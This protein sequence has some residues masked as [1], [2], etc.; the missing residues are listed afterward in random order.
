MLKFKLTICTV[1]SGLLFQ[2]SILNAQSTQTVTKSYNIAD[3]NDSMSVS[4]PSFNTALGTLTGVNILF[5]TSNAGQNNYL[6]IENHSVT[7]STIE[8]SNNHKRLYIDLNVEG[9]TTSVVM[10]LLKRSNLPHTFTAYD[11][12]DDFAGTSGAIFADSAINYNYQQASTNISSFAG[13]GITEVHALTISGF[14]G[15]YEITIGGGNISMSQHTAYNVSVQVTYTYTPS[16]ALALN[17]ISFEGAATKEGNLLT[18]RLAD[19]KDLKTIEI[20]RS[21]SDEKFET[22][23]IPDAQTEGRFMDKNLKAANNLYRLKITD[24]SGNIIYS[25]IRKVTN[26]VRSNQ[27]DIIVYP[28]PATDNK[29]YIQSAMDIKAVTL[30]GVNGAVYNLAT[31]RSESNTFSVSLPEELSAGIYYITIASNSGTASKQLVVK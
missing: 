20:E 29:V 15:A 8:A 30:S 11:G 28:N 18:W 9:T 23:A 21:T 14:E 4:V 27:A 26:S 6:A 12:T 2:S 13:N 25:G 3:L 1:L 24:K 5:S 19:D 31:N 10:E 22:I 17:I 7:P 16:T